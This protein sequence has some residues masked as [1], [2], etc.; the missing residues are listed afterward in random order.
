MASRTTLPSVITRTVP[1]PAPNGMGNGL[2]ATAPI[3]PGEDVLHIK[4]PFLAVLDSPRLEDTCAGCFG[5][6]QVE[7]GNE[8]KACTGC[9]VVKYCDRTC[10]SKDWKFAHSLECPIFKNVKPMVLPNNARALLRVVLRTARNKYDSEESKVFDGLETHI[11][12][13]S[14]SQG[15]LD[16]INLTARAVKNYSGTE[17]DEGTV[18]SYAAKLDLNSF[19]LT[20]SMYDRIGLYMHPYAGLINH[21]CDYNS[22]VGF[23]GEEL[24]VKAMRPIKKGEQIFISY[25]DTT[26]PYDIRR[27]ELKERYFFDCQ[28]TKCK[29]GTETLEDRFLSTPE[30]M[31]PLETAEREALEL[32]QKATASN[33][34]PTDA[35]EKLEAAMHKLHETALWPLTRQPYASL[36][37]KLIISLLTAGNFTRAFIHAAIRYLRID[38]VVYDKAHPIRHIH[39]WSLVRLT[40]FISQ[41]GFQPGPKDPVQIHDFKLNF[42]YL[43]WYILA[44]LTSTQGESCTVPSFRKLV[45]NQF[46]QVH[47]EFKANGLDPSKTRAVLSAEWN[48]LERL[49]DKALEKE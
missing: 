31:T 28:C 4:T 42:H 18:A 22:T 30:D 38:P 9:R 10:Q 26:T 20:T 35:I 2:F 37:D 44:E 39:A 15:Q 3:N 40:V 47:N 45:G 17:M 41:E 11:N 5:K 48:K 34:E 25:I 24:Y 7:T 12:E 33:T 36:R 1:Q 23:D 43:I 27:N 13:I 21:S 6:R 8:L 32:M 14:E 19:N 29:M 49:V 46:V 16:R